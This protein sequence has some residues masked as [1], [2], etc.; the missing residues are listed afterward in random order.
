[1]AYGVSASAGSAPLAELVPGAVWLA[2]GFVD[3]EDELELI[4]HV[5]GSKGGWTGLSGR[6]TKAFGGSVLNDTLLPA[7]LPSFVAALVRR[8]HDAAPGGGTRFF[9]GAPNHVLVNAYATQGGI[10]SHA[11]GPAYAPAVAVVSVGAPAV[12]RFA[13]RGADAALE[14]V[15]SVVV[16]RR[17]ALFF[18]GDACVAWEHRIDRRND[19]ELDDTIT[20]PEDAGPAA[21][22]AG[23]LE[24]GEHTRVSLTVRRVRRVRHNVLRVR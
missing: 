11:D 8:V 24:R 21:L 19:D 17:S 20:N 14:D 18:A 4:A 15:A 5:N 2:R 6:T 13:K 12:L 16:P 1:M 9:G 10:D 7:P 23:L 22:T 3:A